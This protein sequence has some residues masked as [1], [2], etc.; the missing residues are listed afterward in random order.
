[1]QTSPKNFPK[2]ARWYLL[3]WRYIFLGGDALEEMKRSVK[4]RWILL[5]LYQNRQ[6][7]R[8]LVADIL[9]NISD[10]IIM[11][12][13]KR[14]SWFK[15]LPFISFFICFGSLLHKPNE[16]E[17]KFHMKFLDANIS[18]TVTKLLMVDIHFFIDKSIAESIRKFISVIENIHEFFYS[19]QSM[20]TSLKI[21][22][23]LLQKIDWL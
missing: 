13:L 10:L 14:N 19:A 8:T 18:A 15:I 21:R 7:G 16:E 12:T 1:M 5:W 17:I 20:L 4:F 23:R 9:R 3:L 6:Q 22:Q 11:K 2:T